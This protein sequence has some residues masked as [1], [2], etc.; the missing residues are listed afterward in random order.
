M[1]KYFTWRFER[2]DFEANNCKHIR[3]K[4]LKSSNVLYVT[5]KLK[6]NSQ[7]F[8]A[9]LHQTAHQASLQQHP[10]LLHETANKTI[11]HAL[12]NLQGQHPSCLYVALHHVYEDR[13]PSVNIMQSIIA[14]ASPE[15]QWH[16]RVK[17]GWYVCS[18]FRK[19]PEFA[20]IIYRNFWLLRHCL[21]W[22]H[23]QR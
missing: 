6:W 8:S 22:V 19:F 3:H 13:S 4:H 16:V 2:A 14:E 9:S 17:R 18:S 21:L 23:A 7:L 5:L 15:K 10:T 12:S 1:T 20:G 11:W